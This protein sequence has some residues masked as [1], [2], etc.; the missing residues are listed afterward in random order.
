[1]KSNL[2][3]DHEG[4]GEL[5]AEEMDNNQLAPMIFEIPINGEDEFEDY[6]CG[7]CPPSASSPSS[8]GDTWG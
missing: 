3:V 2:A 8:A 5:K 1:M 4:N 6:I 7:R